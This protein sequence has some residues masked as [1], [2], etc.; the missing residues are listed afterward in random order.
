MFAYGWDGRMHSG[1]S[2]PP[3]PPICSGRDLSRTKWQKIKLSDR[4]K[5]AVQCLLP[6]R[7]WRRYVRARRHSRLVR[8]CWPQCPRSTLYAR[9]SCA[10][11][12][13]LW[14]ICPR[15][16]EIRWQCR[17]S[18]QRLGAR[19][20]ETDLVGMHF[21][22]DDHKHFCIVFAT[23]QINVRNR[24]WAQTVHCRCQSQPLF[25]LQGSSDYSTLFM[26]FVHKPACTFQILMRPRKLPEQSTSRIFGL[27]LMVHTWPIDKRSQNVYTK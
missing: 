6:K 7:T 4:H 3:R 27:N 9:A 1:V 21:E 13:T 20:L 22:S 23:Q 24:Q 8:C 5:S 25:S 18:D 14:S 19:H 12:G 26:P 16:D 17:P 15:H 11:F 10:A 2:P